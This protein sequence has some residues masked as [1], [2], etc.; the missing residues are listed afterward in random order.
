MKPAS[1]RPLFQGKSEWRWRD[2]GST[3]VPLLA[4][5]STTSSL[6]SRTLATS[7][8]LAM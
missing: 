8:M 6:V 4:L 1:A 5:L 2:R 7:S 3:L